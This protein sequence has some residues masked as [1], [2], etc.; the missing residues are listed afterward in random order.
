MSLMPPTIGKTGFLFNA[1]NIVD[2]NLFPVA[3]ISFFQLAQSHFLINLPIFNVS[4]LSS[5]LTPT[6]ALD[7][8]D[9]V[10]KE[11]FCEEI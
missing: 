6:V 2:N 8:S 10:R 4:L 11:D 1:V 7:E 9:E 3:F 5:L